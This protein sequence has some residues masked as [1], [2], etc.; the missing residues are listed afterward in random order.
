MTQL[1]LTLPTQGQKN[2]TIAPEQALKFD[3][4]I[5]EAN[6]DRVDNALRI[7][8]PHKGELIIQDFFVTSDDA[9][10]PLFLLEDGTT[11]AAADFLQAMNPNMDI[12]TAMGP[13][14]TPSSGVNAYGDG[15]GELIDGVSSLDALSGLAGWKGALTQGQSVN[16]NTNPIG[17]LTGL[18][19]PATPVDPTNP[20]KP[21]AKFIEEQGEMQLGEYANIDIAGKTVIGRE[22]LH[23]DG[24]LHIHGTGKAD[25]YDKEA[26]TGHSSVGVGDNVVHIAGVDVQGQGSELTLG[27]DY[28]LHI[29]AQYQGLSLGTDDEAESLKVLDYRMDEDTIVYGLK[30][31]EGTTTNL[32]GENINIAG[33]AE[34]EAVTANATEDFG[35]GINFQ[36]GEANDVH[37]A[38]AFVDSSEVSL[39]AKA[40]GDLSLSGRLATDLTHKGDS[41]LIEKDMTNFTVSGLVLG[42][43]DFHHS[44]SSSSEK[45]PVSVTLDAGGNIN[46]QAELEAVSTTVS[47]QEVKQ[48]SFYEMGTI[49]GIHSLAQDSNLTITAVEN[50]SLGAQVHDTINMVFTPSADESH[51]KGAISSRE[52]SYYPSRLIVG[53]YREEGK[54][55]TTNIAAGKEMTI[56]ADIDM[57]K[58]IYLSD[59]EISSNGIGFDLKIY[60][61]SANGVSGLSLAKDNTTTLKAGGSMDISSNNSQSLSFKGSNSTINNDATGHSAHDLPQKLNASL[62]DSS[63]V[64]GATVH[65]ATLDIHANQG[66]T[67][68]T[69]G[70]AEISVGLD[71]NESTTY[72]S[73]TSSVT[74]VTVKGEGTSVG[75][76]NM[77]S[78][79]DI[80]ITA[81]GESIISSLGHSV[82]ATNMIDDSSII[83][84]LSVGSDDY[85]NAKAKVEIRSATGDVRVDASTTSLIEA[86]GHDVRNSL[87]SYGKTEGMAVKP[88]GELVVEAGRNI[89]AHAQASQELNS[90]STGSHSNEMNLSAEV[91]GLSVT[92]AGGDTKGS[93]Q[94]NAGNNLSVQASL[95]QKL[96]TNTQNE[97]GDGN[98]NNTV[99]VSGRVKGL[100]LNDGSGAHLHSGQ[101]MD[102]GAK[103]TVD[104]TNHDITTSSTSIGIDYA[105]VF[106]ISSSESDLTAVSG[107]DLTVNGAF[108]IDY[109][110]TGTGSLDV[111]T[112]ANVYGLSAMGSETSISLNADRNL[113]ISAEKNTNIQQN[114]TIAGEGEHSNVNIVDSGSTLGVFVEDFGQSKVSLE[115]QQDLTISAKNST[116]L[117][118][119]SDATSEFA[120]AQES[121]GNYDPHNVGGLVV[122][123][124]ASPEDIAK[125]DASFVAAARN[126]NLRIEASNDLTT[127]LEG[128]ADS[129]D[130]RITV[131]N[132]VIGTSI[133]NSV[134]S[135]EAGKDIIIGASS[136]T[137]TEFINSGPEGN[138]LGSSTDTH[139]GNTVTGI[140]VSADSQ[141]KAALY[142]E[143]GGDIDIQASLKWQ[144]T[145]KHAGS[146]SEM[147]NS[148][149]SSSVNSFVTGLE[150]ENALLDISAGKNITIAASS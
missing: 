8:S 116:T 63:L 121:N 126:G 45:K 67:L 92:S 30:G 48:S 86:K 141:N 39:N 32:S 12:T 59:A 93:A 31:G 99:N 128:A 101:H 43:E 91:V 82:N 20:E 75:K 64:Q 69:K 58:N 5:T 114:G 96:T 2:I 50:V 143:A 47:G 117:G 115:A 10:L 36:T 26:G 133:H 34:Y 18:G 46:I 16:I 44:S 49:A 28:D 70:K 11:V 6:F 23:H 1:L 3:F 90:Q 79:D 88:G 71:S 85:N 61:K 57:S 65:G 134:A 13:S 119:I 53:G 15:T 54:G 35:N 102:I 68:N 97:A 118:L 41:A 56:S 14:T 83:S 110:G 51:V 142:M 100:E 149:F 138:L 129:F 144:E 77:S 109:E 122:E 89:V 52:S 150:A 40:T 136:N 72:I 84:G 107:G 17:D 66:I 113:V 24:D 9:E 145:L 146:E 125:E 76:L 148:F 22:S 19:A 80:A 60:E 94:L 120:Y 4:S 38:G 132:T 111:G 131:D 135:L 55:N 27:S 62:I 42:D 74:G 130:Q 140:T 112:K 124:Q 25:G 95:S 139:L 127:R 123:G 73:N 103:I 7:S 33:E 87:V 105:E 81:Q 106:G 104:V 78:N 37:I 98:S 108:S 29:E 137:I 21:V 147:E